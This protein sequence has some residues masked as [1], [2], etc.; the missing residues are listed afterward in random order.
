MN[1]RI[2]VSV[3]GAF[4][5]AG[6]ALYGQAQ[7]PAAETPVAP[8]PRPKS[9]PEA[10][11]LQGIFTA[12]DPDTRIKAGDEF[13]TKYQDS[14]FKSLVNMVLAETYRQK[15]DYEKTIIYGERTLEGDPK[16]FMTQIMLAQT[17][18]QRTREFDLDREEKLGRVEKYV[19]EALENLKTAPRPRPNITEDQWQSAKKDFEA[20]AHEA[21]AMA[22]MARNK[23]EVAITEFRSALTLAANPDPATRVRLA[24]MLNKAGKHDEA[25]VEAQKV[26]DTPDAHPQ[27]KSVAQA[28]R[29]RAQAAKGGNKPAATPAPAPAPAPAAPAAPKQ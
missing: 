11:A 15:N 13:L 9:Q 16:N 2:A 4:L 29:A 14:E 8:Q 25:I 12:A 7:A 20:Q 3:L 24:A 10:Q 1:K 19:K 27:V 17:I 5:T 22:A 23:P 28:E 6:F 21:L 18:A 26:I